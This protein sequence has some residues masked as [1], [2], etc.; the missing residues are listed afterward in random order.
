V[1]FQVEGTDIILPNLEEA[2][3]DLIDAC[4]TEEEHVELVVFRFKLP[5]IPIGYVTREQA[6]G[7]CDGRDDTR[8]DAGDWFVGWRNI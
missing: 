8:N 1:T 6:I 5:N 7:Y 2:G 4:D 3:V